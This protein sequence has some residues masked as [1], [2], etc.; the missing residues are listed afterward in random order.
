MLRRIPTVF[1]LPI[2]LLL[3][4]GSDNSAARVKEGKE[5]QIETVE[6][7]IVAN[8]AATLDLDLN[9]LNDAGT[10]SGAPNIATLSFALEPNSFFT[11]VVTNDLLRDA[12]PGSVGLI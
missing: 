8:G 11:I 1:M 3:G 10:T 12:L 4:S 9:R 2:L 7:L 6:R 5:I